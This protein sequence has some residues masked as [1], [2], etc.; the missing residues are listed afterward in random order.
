MMP[1]G[2]SSF[3]LSRTVTALLDPSSDSSDRPQSFRPPPI[4]IGSEIGARKSL[5]KRA[6]GRSDRPRLTLREEPA[7][8]R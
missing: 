7:L 2:G 6:M 5:T 3:K 8:S 4:L 1:D